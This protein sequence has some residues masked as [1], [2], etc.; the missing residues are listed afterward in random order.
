MHILHGTWIPE[1]EQLAVW[2]EDAAAKPQYLKG[3]RG[4][5]A[6]HP[7]S[8]HQETLLG[9][10]E[11]WTTEAHPI[12]EVLTVWLPGK[13]KKVQPSP[14]AQASGAAPLEDEV[15]LLLWRVDTVLLDTLDALD[16]LVQLPDKGERGI[17]LGDDLRY[18]QQ[19]ALLAVNCLVEGRYI[20]ALAREGKQYRAY[21]EPRPDPDLIQQV[22]QNMPP[23]CRAMAEDIEKPPV[24]MSLINH[25]LSEV[26][27]CFIMEHYAQRTAP[28]SPWL[29]ALTGHEM[30]IKDT[31]ANNQRLYIA[32]ETWQAFGGSDGGGNFRICFRLR[33]PTSDSDD[34]DVDYL[35]QANDDP[36]LL[37]ETTEVWSATSG[38]LKYL[39]YR[40][41]RPQEKLLAGLG[42]A[43]R[44]FE[45]IERSLRQAKP[46][47]V[48]LSREEAF[49]FLTEA[50]PLLETSGF[51]V[52][53]PNW[54]GRR[55][56]IQAQ[57]KIK[58]QTN[59]P[60]GILTRNSILR[61]EWQLSLG[62]E[63]HQSRRI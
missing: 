43:S 7:F 27:H 16:F 24:P 17:R 34:W 48:T 58:G 12:P 32:W 57:A 41:D 26:I 23:L 42:L 30:V 3:R 18:W 25:L 13:G 8:V 40:F 31:P 55:A 9:Y 60:T 35:L 44:M 5:T 15:D 36:S 62:G 20:P 59:E 14:Q 37:V 29:R 33:E 49:R 50:L 21:W 4:T 47:G 19:V 28:R 45:P 51:A 54:W 11:Q 52:L 63:C 2:A 38:H 56:R 61:Y 6:P 10:V 39:E 53:V 1:L 46:M 22:A